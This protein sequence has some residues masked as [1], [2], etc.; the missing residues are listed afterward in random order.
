MTNDVGQVKYWPSLYQSIR[1]NV[2]EDLNLQQHVCENLKS[3][4]AVDVAGNLTGHHRFLELLPSLHECEL[5]GP[6][7]ERR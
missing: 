5:R 7:F 1:R 4:T 6:E 2:L 3:R